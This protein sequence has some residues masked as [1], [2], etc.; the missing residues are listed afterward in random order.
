MGINVNAQTK[1]TVAKKKQTAKSPKKDIS[2][3]FE[4]KQYFFVMLKVGPKRDQDS[5]TTAKIQE[6]HM[7]HLTKMYNEGKMD[8]AGPMM[9]KWETKGICVYNVA[10]MEEVKALVEQDPAIVSGRLV[11]EIHPWYAGKGSILR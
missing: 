9:D 1:A 2:K 8:L 3:E 5:I 10:T 7:A 4:M 6:G 11:A